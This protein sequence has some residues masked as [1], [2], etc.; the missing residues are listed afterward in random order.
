MYLE[1]TSSNEGDTAILISPRFQ[2]EVGECQLSFFY[3]MQGENIGQL[4]VHLILQPGVLGEPVWTRVGEQGTKWF[5]ALVNI[6]HISGPFK[7]ISIL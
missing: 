1:S 6:T 4:S 3:H 2:K 7:V 5:E